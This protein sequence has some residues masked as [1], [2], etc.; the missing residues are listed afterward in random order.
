M[1]QI[2][3][4]FRRFGSFGKGLVV[5]MLSIRPDWRRLAVTALVGICLVIGVAGVTK[6]A[7]IA[8]TLSEFGFYVRDVTLVGRYRTQRDVILNA[9][10][11]EAGSAILLV[12]L[13]QKKEDL[14]ALPWIKAA[15]IVRRLP[16]LIH[17]EIIEYE[18]YAILERS[19]NHYLIDRHGYK[20]V[21]DALGSFN[22]LPTIKGLGS[23]FEAAHLLDRL[24]AYPVLRNR[25]VSASWVK[26]RRWTLHL[27]H[28]G[29]VLLP[30]G[31]IVPALDKLMALEDA[32]RVLAVARQTID[33]R[34]TDRILLRFSKGEG[35]QT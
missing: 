16:D 35:A 22:Y 2:I 11:I 19:S 25:L 32:Q 5:G 14:E 24:K 27:D 10:N 18:P 29:D 33:L 6:R 17:V 30:E 15:R 7:E 26:G 4:I 34:L 9:L 23:E 21:N 12:D 8:Q 3:Q 1:S 31:D 13:D 28:G 20:I